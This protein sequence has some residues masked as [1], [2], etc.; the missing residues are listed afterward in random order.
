M[1]NT[2]ILHLSSFLVDFQS[3]QQNFVYRCYR[4]PDLCNLY[5]YF[6]GYRP[7]KLDRGL[8]GLQSFNLHTK[9]CVRKKNLEDGWKVRKPSS[10]TTHRPQ[11][12]RT[13][14]GWTV[15]G[16]LD[17]GLLGRLAVFLCK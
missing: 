12:M 9:T 15:P 11:K 4:I 1:C 8:R 5:L 2:Y 17:D 3:K 7:A 6:S 10:Y 13:W 16:S 14:V